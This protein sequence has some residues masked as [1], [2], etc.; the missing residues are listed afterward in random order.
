MA[1]GVV[2]S[3]GAHAANMLT[4]VVGPITTTAGNLLHAD[5]AVY[6]GAG[7]FSSIAN[8]GLDTWATGKSAFDTSGSVCF[9]QSNY[10]K[11]I[12][13]SATDTITV[14]LTGLG[15]PAVSIIEI[16]GADTSAPLDLHEGG[17]PAGNS[18]T[19]TTTGTTAVANEIVIGALGQSSGIG[20]HVTPGGGFTGTYDD[21]TAGFCGLNQAYKIVSATGTQTY[22]GTYGG[23]SGPTWNEV[24]T[25][26]KQASGGGGTVG[27]G[28]FQPPDAFIPRRRP[29][30]EAQPSVA[31]TPSTLPVPVSG[32][33]WFAP[34]DIDRR[35][36]YIKFDIPPAYAAQIPTAAST[37]SGMAWFQPWDRDRPARK[38]TV[39]A[40]PALALT[41]STLP[42][43]ISGMGWFEPRDTDRRSAIVRLE[44]PPAL[45]LTPLTLPVPVSG[46]GWFE[47]P[48]RDRPSVKVRLE[49]PIAFTVRPPIGTPISGIGWFE[50]PDRDRPKV[51][52]RIEAPPA[53]NLTPSTLPVPISGMGWFEPAD[54]DPPKRKIYIVPPE[55]WWMNAAL[56]NLH[57]CYLPTISIMSNGPWATISLMTNAAVPTQGAMANQVAVI[58]EM[59][60]C[61]PSAAGDLC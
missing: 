61:G 4:V 23:G 11:N 15:Y 24:I 8:T 32:I 29:S 51:K 41:P 46:I 42:V 31:L 43:P 25:T 18:P 21:F 20:N 60:A 33:G 22:S 54:R 55:T 49:S 56:F 13:G 14:T 35:S 12:N 52:I 28:W 45:S 57:F 27:I 48:D 53:I 36:A 17:G 50:P 10:A 6:D 1:L 30:R 40:A 44:S 7:L 59:C 2:Q 38:I 9:N 5:I 19:F 34:R 3:A 47:P 26:Y 58:S 39:E 37:I 16:S